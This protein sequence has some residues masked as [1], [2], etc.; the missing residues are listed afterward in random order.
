VFTGKKYNTYTVKTNKKGLAKINTKSLKIGK[1][2][3]I[4]SSG[5]L[6]IVKAY[7]KSNIIHKIV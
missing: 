2:K 6:L 4:I 7:K 3:V 5:L 1:H